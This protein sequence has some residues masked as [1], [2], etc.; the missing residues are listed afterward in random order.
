MIDFRPPGASVESGELKITSGPSFEAAKT[1]MIERIIQRDE[2]KTCKFDDR[3]ISVT[4]KPDYN[5]IAR[6]RVSWKFEG[7]IMDT[8]EQVWQRS[9]G[10][11]GGG[12]FAQDN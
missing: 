3:E 9:D 6:V 4:H 7:A 5:F 10:L 1:A 11:S 2:R 8:I 12:S